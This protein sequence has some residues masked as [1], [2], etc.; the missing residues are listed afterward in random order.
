MFNNNATAKKIKAMPVSVEA[1][2]AV[3][4]AIISDNEVAVRIVCN[5]S[6]D[7]FYSPAHREI[8]KQIKALMAQNKPVDIIM[9]SNAL[10]REDKLT[11]VGGVTMLAEIVDSIPSTANCDYY[12]TILQ[13][14]SLLRNI[15]RR[16][17]EIISTAYEEED[18]AKVLAVAEA[19][20]YNISQQ[21][22]TNG[23]VHVSETAIEV[24]N[25]LATVFNT[26]EVLGGLKV[27]ISSLDGETNG[28]RGG[29]LIVLAAR[30]GC[31]KTTFAMN[32]VAN[33]I[34]NSETKDKV[35]AVF[36]LEMSA[37][38]LVIRLISNLAKV[39]SKS[40]QAGS[41]SMQELSR[42]WEASAV[43]N[44]S[45][46]FIDDSSLISAEQIL[47]KC[48][49]LKAQKGALDLVVV[50]YLQLMDT[51]VANKNASK[52][53]QVSETSRAMK[54]LAKELNVPVILLSQMSRSIEQRDD[55]TPM[56]SDLRESGAIEQDADMV[57]FLTEG[58]FEIYQENCAAIYLL[59]AKHRNGQTG[60]FPLKWEK[61]LMNFVPVSNIVVLSK[62]QKE[63]AKK[64]QGE[65]ENEKAKDA[66]QEVE[67]TTQEAYEPPVDSDE[68]PTDYNDR[69]GAVKEEKEMQKASDFATNVI[70]KTPIN[71][72]KAVNNGTNV[73]A[74]V[75]KKTDK[76]PQSSVVV[77]EIP[78]DISDKPK[79]QSTNNIMDEIKNSEMKL[80]PKFEENSNE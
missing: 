19:L 23:L 10:E 17:N 65:K 68:V 21:K 9:L 13:R 33:V 59:L 43:L 22:E 66:P 58:D 64:K 38:E 51:T 6:E 49:R 14:N 60:K 54:I 4:A 55:K 45:N 27:G 75:Q 57:M 78:F 72:Q 7:D 77:S 62:E 12:V 44:E 35:V 56:L 16:C 50:D 52:Q 69:I 8:F 42:M 34:K 5:L 40:L 76:E 3:L 73:T 32:M 67:A 15:I 1:E 31:G 53:Q 18:A 25:L 61:N 2:Q 63:A 26:K 41:Q 11:N 29:Q 37:K 47:S 30:P 39:D 70:Q 79:A 28:F 71:E 48:R 24:A 74:N 20:I 46:V 80:E 36:N